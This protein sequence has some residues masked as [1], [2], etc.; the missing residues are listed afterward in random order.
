MRRPIRDWKDMLLRFGL[1]VVERSRANRPKRPQARRLPLESLEIRQM[2]AADSGSG[3][4]TLSGATLNV[5]AAN[6]A[7]ASVGT[8]TMQPGTLTYNS[9]VINMQ[10]SNLI[11]Q[12]SSIA[13]LGT[14]NQS[15][16]VDDGHA[17]FITTGSWINQSGASFSNSQRTSAA[18]GGENAARWLFENLADGDFDVFATWQPTEEAASNAKFAL[19][20]DGDAPNETIIDQSQRPGYLSA[21]F[22]SGSRWQRLGT[23]TVEDGTLE[24]RLT[25]DADG[26]VLG[27]AIR[28]APAVASLPSY[29]TPLVSGP[30]TISEGSLYT[31]SLDASGGGGSE[32]RVDWGDGTVETYGIGSTH[33]THTYADGSGTGTART[34]LASVLHGETLIDAAPVEITTQNVSSA[35]QLLSDDSVQAGEPFNTAFSVLSSVESSSIDCDSDV[36]SPDSSH[37]A[38]VSH[39]SQGGPA[40]YFISA[41]TDADDIDHSH[42]TGSTNSLH[43]KNVGLSGWVSPDFGRDNLNEIYT[44]VVD[45]DN[46]VSSAGRRHRPLRWLR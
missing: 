18:G 40:K 42:L 7:V 5:A 29:V 17:H 3:T 33:I 22:A 35:M 32:W 45:C 37:R 43:L 46:F 24:V 23:L 44:T 30:S 8:L 25:N 21:H 38:D 20:A 14:L 4:Y 13:Q 9:G 15:S 26:I 2:L 39:V 10:G 36:L 16:I 12:G 27:D 19:S 28:I 41:G 6:Y 34:I 31:L 1:R 11:L